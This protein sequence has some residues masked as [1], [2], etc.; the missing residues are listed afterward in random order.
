MLPAETMTRPE[1]LNR[2]LLI[3]DD[4]QDFAD[5]MRNFLTLEGYEVECAYGSDHAI[6]TPF[7]AIDS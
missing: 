5:S 2:R 7:Y 1:N 3:V 4:D 6:A